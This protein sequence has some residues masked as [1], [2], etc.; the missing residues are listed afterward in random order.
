MVP[1]LFADAGGGA[2]ETSGGVTQEG[3]AKHEDHEAR[4]KKISRRVAYRSLGRRGSWISLV[5]RLWL[6]LQKRQKIESTD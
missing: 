1:K 3:K 2:E 5:L 6:L 4:G